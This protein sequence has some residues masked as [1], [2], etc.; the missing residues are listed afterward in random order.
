MTQEID[1]TQAL[2]DIRA[3]FQNV[4]PRII[5]EGN[6]VRMTQG[7]ETYTFNIAQPVTSTSILK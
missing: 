2:A 7:S 6:V 5:K 1:Y 3:G 4:L